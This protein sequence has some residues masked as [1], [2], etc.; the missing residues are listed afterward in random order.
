MH[1]LHRSGGRLILRMVRPVSIRT[2]LDQI[3][4]WYR[5]NGKTVTEVP[6]NCRPRTLSGFAKKRE[7]GGPYIYRGVIVVGIKSK[8]EAPQQA[9][10]E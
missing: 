4:D 2:E 7:R 8:D 9:E 6:V 5:D 1:P 10:I 3:L